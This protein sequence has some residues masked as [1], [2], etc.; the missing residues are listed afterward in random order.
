MAMTGF[1]GTRWPIP[2]CGRLSLKYSWY[3]AERAVLRN[4][5][6][7]VAVVAELAPVADAPGRGSMRLAVAAMFPSVTSSGR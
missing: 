7:A 2:W 3:L 6:R 4:L 1:A 5:G